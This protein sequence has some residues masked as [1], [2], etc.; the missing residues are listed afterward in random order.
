MAIPSKQIGGS[1]NYNLL[2]QISKQLDQLI[3]IR[4]GGCTTTTTT[5]TIPV[6][7]FELSYGTSGKAEACGNPLL[8]TYYSSSTLLTDGVILY[9]DINLSIVVPNGWYAFIDANV[10][11][12]TDLDDGVIINVT[13]CEE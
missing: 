1:V 4:S 6:Y 12:Q 11:Y 10:V 9:T 2:W 5:T 8:T 3:C 7:Q 13:Y